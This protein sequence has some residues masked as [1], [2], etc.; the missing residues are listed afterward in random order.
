M[1]EN[2]IIE[3][4]TPYGISKKKCEDLLIEHSLKN[5]IKLII[6]R[7]FNIIG[8]N[9]NKKY[10]LPYIFDSILN[11]KNIT[12]NHPYDIRDFIGIENVIEY[13]KF[14]L[15]DCPK[16]MIN[17]YNLGSGNGIKIIDII[18]YIKKISRKEILCNIN[19]QLK[20]KAVVS[21]ANSS[22]ISTYTNIKNEFDA[23]NYITNLYESVF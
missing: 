15:N 23:Y 4:K 9:Q 5:N 19:S 10:L 14:F 18:G 16:N 6:I 7:P 11:K 2:F 12:I 22:K 21:I 1:D 20:S 13:I 8:K 3:P 17:I